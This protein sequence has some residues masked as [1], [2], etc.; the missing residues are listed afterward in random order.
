MF[1]YIFSSPA[2]GKAWKQGHAGP[3]VAQPSVSKSKSHAGEAAGPGQRQRK[4]TG[5]EDAGPPR[6]Q[7]HAQAP[8]LTR[9]PA[10]KQRGSS[11]NEY[12]TVNRYQSDSKANT[13]NKEK[14][15]IKPQLLPPE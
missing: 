5:A 6:R 8:R 2:Q 12:I 4:S 11:S 3:K 10:A 15:H 9:P 14:R 13:R 1:E 7:G